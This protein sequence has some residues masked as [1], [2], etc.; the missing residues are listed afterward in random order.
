MERSDSELNKE[1]KVNAVKKIHNRSYTITD[2]LALIATRCKSAD[3]DSGDMSFFISEF[4]DLISTKE[5]LES[6][7]ICFFKN[8]DLTEDAIT[9]VLS[10]ISRKYPT[11]LTQKLIETLIAS[12][13]SQV[14]YEVLQII[15]DKKMKFIYPKLNEI[16]NTERNEQVKSEISLTLNRLNQ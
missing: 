15:A 16:L 14:R 6:D 1:I 7:L 10:F 8:S 3:F 4:G 11:K 13:F 2:E 9:E 5:V 12:S